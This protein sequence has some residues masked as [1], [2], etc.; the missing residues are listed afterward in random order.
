MPLML[1]AT[2][3]CCAVLVA[4]TPLRLSI[5]SG[6][7]GDLFA[8]TC[9]FWDLVLCG[10]SAVRSR[11]L[12]PRRERAK[13]RADARVLV[14]DLQS[15][16][17]AGL[18]LRQAFERLTPTVFTSCALREALGRLCEALASGMT[19]ASALCVQG[20]FLNAQGPEARLLGMSFLGLSVC[21]RLGANPRALL[22]SAGARLEAR[23]EL[24][25]RI[26]VQTALVRAQAVALCVAPL[27]ALVL[28]AAFVPGASH[29]YAHAIAGRACAVCVGLLTVAGALW[30][31][32]LVEKESRV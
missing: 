29:F 24:L 6:R 16:L 14:D 32:S 15:S 25:R 4:W 8:A 23:T 31:Q 11:W 27:A 28:T 26:R 21:E 12:E 17:S 30:T 3:L 19:L 22:S 13:L 18:H 5:G 20:A 7:T 1:D 2:T 10:S 9:P